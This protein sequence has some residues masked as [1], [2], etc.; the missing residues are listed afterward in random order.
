MIL[1]D[2]PIRKASSII[3]HPFPVSI[4]KAIVVQSAAFDPQVLD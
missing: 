1:V 3:S 4:I 2:D